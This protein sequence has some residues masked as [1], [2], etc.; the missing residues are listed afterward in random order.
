MQ[1][2][3]QA[4]QISE[5]QRL[6][7]EPAHAEPKPIDADLALESIGEQPHSGDIL[8][9]IWC[10]LTAQQQL[11]LLDSVLLGVQPQTEIRDRIR[12]SAESWGR[13]LAEAG[14]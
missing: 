14:L 3:T 5:N 2:Q 9:D 7:R 4:D 13:H 10:D 12:K 11:E 8:T 6:G 1:T